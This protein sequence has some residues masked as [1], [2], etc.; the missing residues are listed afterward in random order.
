MLLA[1]VSSTF[2]S[3]VA[4]HG[5][6]AVFGLMAIDALF[7]AASELVMLYAG[8]VAAGVFSAANGVT[9]FGK[10]IGFGA[11]AYVALALAGTLGYLVGALIGWGIGR[12]GGRPLVER[13]G[14]WFHLSPARFERAEAWFDRW[15]NLSVFLGR[16]TPVIRSFVSIAAG[17]FEMRLVPYTL[18]SLAGSAVWAFAFAGAGYGLGKSYNGF[19]HGFHYVEYV[20]AAG[21]VL[22]LVYLVY[23][24]VTAARVEPRADDSTR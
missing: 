18:L 8:A 15:G 21:I 1:S 9:L 16:I 14:R 6:Y 17:I 23:R 22:G 4:N 2:T 12:Y 11:G 10:Q 24:W 20:I 13:H 3:A 5:L 19:D 7:P